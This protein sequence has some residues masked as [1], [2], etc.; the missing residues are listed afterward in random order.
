ME[1]STIRAE[2]QVNPTN[3]GRGVMA[4]KVVHFEFVTGLRRRIFSN[5]RLRGS[6]DASGR[7]ADQWIETPMAE[8]I[9]DDGCPNFTA[10]VQFDL[11]DGNKTFKWG[12]VLDGPQG[13]NFWGI[14]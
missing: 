3:G 1:T 10:T 5:T 2:C 11:V 12:V 7:Y 4:T 14:P 6:W 13:A 8:G 9:G